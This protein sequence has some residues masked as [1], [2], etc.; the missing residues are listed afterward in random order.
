MQAIKLG[1]MAL[2][3]ALGMPQASAWDEHQAFMEALARTTPNLD[4]KY[5]Y[6]P[7]SI[8]SV[9][10]EKKI[11]AE[12][13]AGL[14]INVSK[15]PLFSESHRSE[16]KIEVHE[17]LKSKMID[18]PDMGMDQD[19]PDSYD[20]QGERPWMGGVQGVTSQGFRHMY[21][22]GFD[23][24]Q[25]LLSFQLPFRAV[26]QAP[27][28]FQK[29]LA[30]SDRFFKERQVFWGVRTLMW[31][32]HY[33]QDLHQPFHVT[34]VPNWKFLPLGSL[35]S[36]F[37]G[38][39]TQSIGNYHFAYEGFA[40]VYL[41]KYDQLLFRDCIEADGVSVSEDLHEIIEKSRDGA[42]AIAEPLYEI[43]GPGLKDAAIDIPRGVGVPDYYRILRSTTDENVFILRDETCKLMKSMAQYT[44]GQI[45]RAFQFFPA[46]SS[47]SKTGR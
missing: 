22:A 32:L 30:L 36:G 26:G 17:L 27:T 46:Q 7:V 24:K 12:I 23:Y 45:D 37:I 40:L 43:L 28:R 4:R 47:S 21:F 5:L 3:F 18:E 25:P 35:F 38:R 10:E 6:Q 39:T 42:K 34:Q 20:P 9:E 15:V 14:E 13:A 2:G 16:K 19:L 1:I 8:P 41:K 33:L 29:W 31:A 11:L 44:W